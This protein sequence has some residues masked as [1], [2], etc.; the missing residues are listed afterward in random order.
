MSGERCGI[1][2]GAI[3]GEDRSALSTKG[4]VGR[5]I[6]SPRKTVGGPCEGGVEAEGRDERDEGE[7]ELHGSSEIVERAARV[8]GW[9]G[10]PGSELGGV[11]RLKECL[12][13]RVDKPI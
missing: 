7:R 10:A 11:E 2:G 9:E 6:V 1:E 3:D 4:A 13:E 5:G 8:S 12:C